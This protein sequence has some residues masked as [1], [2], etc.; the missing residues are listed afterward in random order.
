MPEQLHHQPA[1]VPA[2]ATS[3]FQGLLRRLHT[4]L[5]ADGVANIGLQPLVQCHQK[6]NGGLGR[7]VGCIHI[8]LD[9]GRQ[10]AAH[11]VRSQFCF[12]RFA[13]SKR[14]SFGL[15]LQEKIE[16]IEH[17]H[18][19][20]QINRHLEFT[21]GFWKHQPRL[22]IGKRVLLPVGEVTARLDFER[23]RQNLRTAVRRWPQT[24]H[25]RS[26]LD[27]PVITVMGDMAERYMK[28]H[29]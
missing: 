15:R 19:G 24:D 9:Q 12:L 21:R 22:V 28:G 25:L 26:Q 5:H 2:R 17:R 18:F 27:R 6:I 10:F 3:Q 23:I 13:V 4:R 7:K 11:Q 20:N 8:T 1:R 29:V 16:G 14:E